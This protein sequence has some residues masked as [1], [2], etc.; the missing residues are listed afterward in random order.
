M[1]ELSFDA[2]LTVEI[3][4]VVPATPFVRLSSGESRE[5]VACGPG[6]TAVHVRATFPAYP[7]NGVTDSA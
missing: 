2:A 1:E 6:F 7:F 4:A 5:Q 3:V